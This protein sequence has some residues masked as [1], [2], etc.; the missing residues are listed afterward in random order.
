MKKS[1]NS[2]ALIIVLILIGI[3]ITLFIKGIRLS[4]DITYYENELGVLK[5]ENDEIE[6]QIYKLESYTII[7]SHAAELKYGK[8]NEPIYSQRPRYALK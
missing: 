3:N 5:D 4:D 8:Y 2:I 6:Q 7:A 1:L